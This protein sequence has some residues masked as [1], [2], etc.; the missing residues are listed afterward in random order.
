[1]RW[2]WL[3]L[4]LGAISTACNSS[5]ATGSAC[6]SAG[7][8]CAPGGGWCAKAAPTSE[9]DC[10]PSGGPYSPA[11]ESCCLVFADAAALVPPNSGSEDAAAPP[12]DDGGRLLRCSASLATAC[13]DPTGVNIPPCP[14]ASA[15]DLPG[16]W[17]A[18]N[19]NAGP[20]LGSCGGYLAVVEGFET[21]GIVFYLYSA[22]T[23]ALVAVAVLGDEV[24]LGC[25]GGN[26]DFAIPASCFPTVGFQA[27]DTFN[28]PGGAAGCSAD[29]VASDAGDAGDT[30]AD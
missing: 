2:L 1:M 12:L 27:S 22:Q 21:D 19:P 17:C 15:N 16:P 6:Q 11:G 13:G 5:P 29:D 3:S 23:R 10:I 25:A 30:G 24:T 7:G 26:A 20:I 28:G 14:P 8:T 9:Q 18:A 4:V